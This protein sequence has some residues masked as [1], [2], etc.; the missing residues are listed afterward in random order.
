[1]VAWPAFSWPPNDSATKVAN[2]EA[3]VKCIIG[4]Y[5]LRV[6]LEPRGGPKS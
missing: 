4:H 2:V 5:L 3:A 1:M 6:F